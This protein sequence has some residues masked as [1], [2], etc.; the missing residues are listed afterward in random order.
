MLPPS[1]AI[2]LSADGV[3]W[4]APG[5]EL[6]V[7]PG[8]PFFARLNSTANV[9]S[10]TWSVISTDDVGTPPALTPSGLVNSQVTGTAGVAGTALILQSSINDLVDKT[11]GNV[12]PLTTQSTVAVRVACLNGLSVICFD[13]HGE[14]GSQWWLPLVNAAI[15]GASGISS[16]GALLPL[17]GLATATGAGGGPFW[18]GALQPSVDY[19][20]ATKC[21]LKA[22]LW[23]DHTGSEPAWTTTTYSPGNIVGNANGGG[24]GIPVVYVC[25]TGGTASGTHGPVGFGTNLQDQGG[26]ACRWRS[27]EA[28]ITVVDT[29]TNT[30]LATITTSIT[31][32]AALAGAGASLLEVSFDLSSVLIGFSSPTLIEIGLAGDPAD[33]GGTKY[34]VADC[35]NARLIFT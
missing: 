16:T 33:T 13:E 24:T 34:T 23:C 22:T 14:H 21:V 8:A 15:R 25:T 5:A 9:D 17:T 18:A 32:A 12:N 27:Q 28:Q 26:S 35:G 4:G 7:S 3:T 29:S 1:P 31:A 19:P 30:T 2:Q 11:T 20:G 10:T 6:V